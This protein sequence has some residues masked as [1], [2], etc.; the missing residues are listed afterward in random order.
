MA[1]EKKNIWFYSSPDGTAPPVKNYQMSA[2]PSQ[3][4]FMPGAPVYMED[5]GLIKRV[6]T[7]G[8]VV[9]GYVVGVVDTS[10]AWPLT[11]APA[12][13][14]EFR[15]AIVRQDD[16]YA[17]FADS[18]GTDNTV[19][20]TMVGDQVGI[21]VDATAGKIGYATVNTNQDSANFFRIVDLMFNVSPEKN[22]VLTT[23]PGI[24]LVKHVGTLHG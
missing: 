22:A 4:I 10:T 24:L 11:A 1:T 19:A 21:T 2:D 13:G 6:V 14:D 18:D 23:N 20:Q 5:T 16:I 15:V 17:G 3:G 12:S 9:L 8:Q 7:D